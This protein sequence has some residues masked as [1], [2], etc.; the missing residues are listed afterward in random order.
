M[1]DWRQSM[2]LKSPMDSFTRTRLA[3][4]CIGSRTICATSAT[5]VRQFLEVEGAPCQLVNSRSRSRLVQKPYFGGQ[6]RC[7]AGAGEGED[8][9]FKKEEL[10]C[11]ACSGEVYLQECPK[12]GSE[13]MYVCLD[14]AGFD[15]AASRSRDCNDGRS[16]HKCQYCCAAATWFCWGKAHFCVNCHDRQLRGDYVS[17]YPREK[18]PVC[19]G[20]ELC[21]LK[22]EHPPNGTP[23]ALGCIICR[24]EQQF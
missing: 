3:T 14:A 8:G 24:Q 18:L 4:R 23:F 12:H 2:R 21:P 19:P 9:Q 15:R 7:G 16:E 17:R 1:K 20:R 5:Y 11:G 22:I 13:F 6:R 10:I